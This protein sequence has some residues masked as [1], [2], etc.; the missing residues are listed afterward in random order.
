MTWGSF[1]TVHLV[2]LALAVLLNVLVYLFIRNKSRSVQILFL[3]LLSLIGAGFVAYDIFSNADD[4]LRHLPLSFWSLNM[5]LLPFA[6]VTRGKRI[7]NCLLIWSAASIIALVFNSAMAKI[8]IWS[9]EFIIFF[10]AH[11]F[12]AGIPILLFEMKLVNRDTGTV[13]LTLFATISAYISV[14]VLNLVINSS[15]EW[16]IN[17]G[18]NYMATLESN[19]SLLDFFYAL[20]PSEFWYMVLAL[21]LLFVY[22]VYWYLPEILDQRRRNKPLREKLHDID[23]Y[24]D[25]YEEE[26]IDEIIKKKYK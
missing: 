19:S 11:V 10:L 2:T 4:I 21:P 17:N 7:C 15:N 1:G 18:V 24:Y 20:I 6:V 8:D 22:I 3:F 5:L 13:K 12:S 25:A 23:R 16:S 14:H 26:Y 9:W